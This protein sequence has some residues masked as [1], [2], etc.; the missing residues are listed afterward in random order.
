[1]NLIGDLR[2]VILIYYS[3]SKSHRKQNKF[4][5]RD[6]HINVEGS[7]NRSLQHLN[8][9]G[10]ANI[11]KVVI[12]ASTHCKSLSNLSLSANIQEVNLACFNLTTLNLG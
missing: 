11:K 2:L 8:C 6:D 3:D 10:C 12:P 4:D 1:M 7:P 5:L 9:V